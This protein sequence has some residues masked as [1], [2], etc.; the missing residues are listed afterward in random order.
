MRRKK[1]DYTDA[2][3][4]WL[5]TYADMVTLLLTFFVLLFSMSTLNSQKWQKLVL[6]LSANSV[7]SATSSQAQ[8]VISPSSKASSMAPKAAAKDEGI[9]KSKKAVTKVTDFDELYAYLKQYIDKN[10]LQSQVEIYKGEG[11]TFLSFQNSIFFDGNSAVLRDEGKSILDFLNNAMSGIPNQIGEIRFYGHTAQVSNMDT[12][13]KVEFD[14]TLSTDRANNVLL[15]IQSKGVISGDKMESTG[16]GQFHPKVKE[17]GTE[18]TLS[19]N[20]RVEIYI[21]KTG[22]TEDIL[23]KV[24][25][26]IA[27]S[28]KSS[29]STSSK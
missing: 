10:N 24:Y 9:G 2:S 23:N 4:N 1:K 14:R 7:K 16:W 27:A 8:I 18:A 3:P 22:K 5:D 29:Q 6:A 19:K 26:D 11:Y 17:D 15:Y 21:S 13:E 28:S 25:A 20:R 12:S